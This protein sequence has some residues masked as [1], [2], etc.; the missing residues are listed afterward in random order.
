[1][2]KLIVST[3]V[4]IMLLSMT[5]FASDSDL[6]ARVEALEEKVLELET[7]LA[8]LEG[9]PLET[10]VTTAVSEDSSSETDGNVLVDNEYVTLTYI[11]FEDGEISFDIKNNY[12]GTIECYLNYIQVDGVELSYM[13]DDDDI[14]PVVDIG[15]GQTR[16][17]EFTY[18]Q[19]SGLTGS[20]ING[21]LDVYTDNVD[22]LF[23]PQFE[24][25]I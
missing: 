8:E 5:A 15:K 25:S 7:R 23:V 2:K 16:S 24:F 13:D 21:L 3:M 20:T 4:G 17:Y 6:E 18:Q 19:F 14:L 9:K 12:E 22:D 11:G 10:E 1:M